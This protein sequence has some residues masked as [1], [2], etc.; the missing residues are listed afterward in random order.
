MYSNANQ[1]IQK[2]LRGPSHLQASSAG[3]R[4]HGIAL[5]QHITPV[6]EKQESAID[7]F[8][9]CLWQHSALGPC[10]H[11]TSRGTFVPRLVHPDTLSLFRPGPVARVRPRLS[12]DIVICAFDKNFLAEALDESKEEGNIRTITADGSV[13]EDQ[14]GFSDPILRN[15]LRKLTYEAKSDGLLGSL[16]AESQINALSE[17]LISLTHTTPQRLRRRAIVPGRKLHRILERIVDDPLSHVD[18]KTLAAE[19]GYSRRQFLR[20]FHETTGRT[21]HQY[22]LDIR[23]ERARVLLEDRCLDLIEIAYRCG[24]ASHAHLTRTFRLRFG[25]PPSAF[26]RVLYAGR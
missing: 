6:G 12:C 4:W 5:E 8:L 25:M 15:I 17:R 19:S 9:L 14:L 1:S 21:P 26:R 7:E 3:L 16:Y 11:P 23:L 20:S 24:F 2:F 13:A 18:L 10:D 22:I